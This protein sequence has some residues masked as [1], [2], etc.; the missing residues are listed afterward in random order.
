VLVWIASQASAESF[1][2]LGMIMLAGGGLYLIAAREGV[3]AR[4]R[5]SSGQ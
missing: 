1:R 3:V 2:M 5:R 4:R